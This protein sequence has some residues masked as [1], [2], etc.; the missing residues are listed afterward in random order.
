MFEHEPA[1]LPWYHVVASTLMLTAAMRTV[2]ASR[3]SVDHGAEEVQ[4][5]ASH[6]DNGWKSR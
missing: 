5:F 3:L 2:A 1:A 6:E 4:E